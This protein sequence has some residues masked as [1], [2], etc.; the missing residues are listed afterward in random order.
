[1]SY[2]ADLHLHSP[3]A[4]GTS[5]KLRFHEMARWAKLKGIDLLASADFTHPEWLRETASTLREAGDGLYECDGVRFVLGTEVACHSE[6]GGRKRRVHLLLFLPSLEAVRRLNSAL[7]PHGRLESD[8][9][10]IL[11]LSPR[12]LTLVMREADPRGFVV[13]AHAWTP[14]FGVFGSKSGFDSLEECFGDAAKYVRAVETGLSSEPAM[15]HRVRELDG[16]SIV[17]FSDAHSLPKMGRELTVFA[18]EPNYD[19]LAEALER[20]AVEYTVEMF[21]QEGKYHYSGHRK[22]GVSLSPPEVRETGARCPECG[23]PMT[24]GV[25]QRV[26]E[27]SDRPPAPARVDEKGLTAG[28]DGRPPFRMLVSLQQIVSESLGVGVAA[29]RTQREWLKLCQELDGELNVLTEASAD[30]VAEVSGDRIAEGVARVRQGDI[31]IEPGYDGRY[32][33]VSVW[34][35]QPRKGRAR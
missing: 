1:M 32:G 31:S 18:G 21:P 15:N 4:R 14:W 9:R 29:K 25:M 26:E 5:D 17:S 27:I 6:Q 10:P 28:A 19:G 8:G 11:H 2:A 24:L 20:Q 30:E 23:R 22:C 34:P 16:R 3:Y 13:P 7:A 33:V 12:E 35:Q